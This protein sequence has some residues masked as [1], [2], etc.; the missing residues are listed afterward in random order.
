MPQVGC[1]LVSASPEGSMEKTS[2]GP[3]TVAESGQP[4]K[5]GKRR[6]VIRAGGEDRGGPLPVSVKDKSGS[7]S[8]G[9]A[10]GRRGIRGNGGGSRNRCQKMGGRRVWRSD[11]VEEPEPA[12]FA[13]GVYDFTYAALGQLC[14]SQGR[15][16]GQGF[17]LVPCPPPPHLGCRQ[18]TIIIHM[19]VY[20]YFNPKGAMEM[21]C[22][23]QH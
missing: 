14:L 8:G 5:V 15:V 19:S 18:G 3:K 1:L 21:L 2:D 23:K 17:D 16:L 11:A 20:P 7:V 9:Q 12:L 13:E 4:A 22:Q 10:E 6:Y